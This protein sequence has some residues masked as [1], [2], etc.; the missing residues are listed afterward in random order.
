LLKE[1]AAEPSS[2]GIKA[3]LKREESLKK[4]KAVA[5]KAAPVKPKK[6]AVKAESKPGPA[7]PPAAHKADSG[8]GKPKKQP[9][10]RKVYDLPG[11]RSATPPEV[12][13]ARLLPLP[14]PERAAG[15]S[16]ASLL[17]ARDGFAAALLG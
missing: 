15:P 10:E 16:A 7:K 5:G 14:R 2:K 8:N 13:P 1:P 11:Q 6:E 9:V 3:P 4:K 12:R 17:P